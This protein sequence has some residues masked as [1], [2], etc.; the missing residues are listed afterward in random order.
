MAALAQ[1]SDLEARLGRE[2]TDAEAAR[3][4]ALLDDASALV[5]DYT[6]R[7]FEVVED[8]VIVLRAVGGQIKLPQTPVAEV[9]SVVVVGGS[10]A[11]PDFTLPDWAFDG[12]DTVKVG[13]GSYVINLPEVWW[14]DDGYP[15]TFRVTYTH[16][17]TT[18][19]PSV[20]AV[21]CSM[22][23][24]TLTTPAMSGALTSETIGSYS[25]RLESAGAGLAVAMSAEEQR[26]LRRYRRTETTI[27]VTR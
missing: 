16:G 2:L 20:V 14:D 26:T 19:P 4:E 6:K 17:Y 15:G 3:V 5:R 8:D 18:V 13:D 11:L 7:T 21:V 10:D 9:S 23:N 24:R 22:V 25:Y 12:I 27:K 1:Q